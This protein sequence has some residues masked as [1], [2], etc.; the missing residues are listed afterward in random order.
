MIEYVVQPVD[1][2]AI[3]DVPTGGKGGAAAAGD[4]KAEGDDEQEP[5]YGGLGLGA[6][7][8][9]GSGGGGEGGEEGQQQQQ[10]ALV[11]LGALVC[12][13]VFWRSGGAHP[14]ARLV[15]APAL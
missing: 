3:F 15:Q 7:P 14:A 12:G 8:G 10:Q 4:D 2:T 6:A 11:S 1:I 13:G 9:L 5:A